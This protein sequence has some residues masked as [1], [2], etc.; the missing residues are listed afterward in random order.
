MRRAQTTVEYM[1]L[2]SVLCIALVAVMLSFSDLVQ[3]N[4][5]SLSTFLARELFRQRHLIA[6]THRNLDPGGN[7]ARTAIDQIHAF[8]AVQIVLAG[9]VKG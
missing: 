4:T 3:V 6:R 1:L 5:R 7:P 2:I 8:A 9:L